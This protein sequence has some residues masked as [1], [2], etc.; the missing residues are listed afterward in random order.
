MYDGCLQ[1]VDTARAERAFVGRQQSLVHQEP[2]AAVWQREAARVRTGGLE[3][4]QVEPDGGRQSRE[5]QTSRRE[6]T[7]QLP[8]HGAEVRRIAGEVKHRAAE[9]DIERPVGPTQ[10]IEGFVAHPNLRLIGA[11]RRH[12]RADRRNGAGIGVHRMNAYALLQQEHQVASAATA[13]VEH[14]VISPD[15]P[16]EELIEHIDVDVAKR[17]AQFPIESGGLTPHGGPLS[18]HMLS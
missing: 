3:R 15:V 18:A 4:T 8:H 11:T 9:H 10:A 16:S 2:I 6:D 13:R 1:R 12:E 7:P 5:E 17:G 14:S